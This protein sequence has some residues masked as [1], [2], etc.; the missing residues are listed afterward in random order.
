[1]GIRHSQ[2]KAMHIKEGHFALKK[3]WVQG[4]GWNWERARSPLGLQ[5]VKAMWGS[6]LL[7]LPSRVSINMNICNITS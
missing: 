3:R 6:L 1:M 7:L 2:G 5:T 4:W